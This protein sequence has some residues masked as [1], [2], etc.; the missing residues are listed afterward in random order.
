MQLLS[1]VVVAGLHHLCSFIVVHTGCTGG[2]SRGPRTVKQRGAALG[3]SPVA[4]CTPLLEGEPHTTR[5]KHTSH[6]VPDP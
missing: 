6:R 2:C 1:L 5:N 3:S 4:H